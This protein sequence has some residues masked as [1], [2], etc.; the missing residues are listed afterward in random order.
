M[1]GSIP[2]FFVLASDTTDSTWIGGRKRNQRNIHL[3]G[4]SFDTT[5]LVFYDPMSV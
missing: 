4:I 2:S 3:H 1:E 5:V